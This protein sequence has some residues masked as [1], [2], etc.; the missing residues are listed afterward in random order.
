MCKDFIENAKPGEEC[1]CGL[2]I[3]VKEWFVID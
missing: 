3:K 2:Y 1:H